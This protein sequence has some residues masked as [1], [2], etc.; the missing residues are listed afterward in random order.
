[1]NWQTLLKQSGYKRS[2]LK[3]INPETGRKI[4]RQSALERSAKSLGFKN[5]TDAKSAWKTKAYKRLSE[6]AS[7]EGKNPKGL[8]FNK[9]FGEAWKNRKQKRKGTALAKLLKYV[10]K[11]PQKVRYYD[12]RL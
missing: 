7:D 1:M 11:I 9:L 10:N 12:N 6:Y 3:Y 4:T 8:E 2:G 5:Y